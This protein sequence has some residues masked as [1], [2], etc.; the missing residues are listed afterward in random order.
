MEP[1]NLIIFM[2]DEHTR[3]VSGCY[4]HRETSTPTR[5]LHFGTT[6]RIR[7]DGTVE[8]RTVLSTGR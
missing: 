7:G 8:V 1:K 5:S 6:R 4:G 3:S 2:S